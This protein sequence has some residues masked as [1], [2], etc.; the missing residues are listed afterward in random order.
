M[1][2]KSQ[3]SARYLFVI[4]AY[5]GNEKHL[6]DSYN[7]F[8]NINEDFHFL[9]RHY[10][11]DYAHP[12]FGLTY[13]DMNPMS[14]DKLLSWATWAREEIMF[15]RKFYRN[16]TL[17]L[18]NFQKPPSDFELM[19]I[20]IRISQ[21]MSTVSP[22][23]I[24][25]G[26]PDNWIGTLIGRIA[27]DLCIPNGYAFE[28]SILNNLFFNSFGYSN[29]NPLIVPS[30]FT[31]INDD[32][33][34]PVPAIELSMNRKDPKVYT[35]NRKP[36]VQRFTDITQ[37]EWHAF[38]LLL[39][40]KRVG[41]SPWQYADHWFPILS[42]LK[43]WSMK[44]LGFWNRYQLR[45]WEQMGWIKFVNSTKPRCLVFLHA[46]PEAATLFFGRKL[47]TQAGFIKLL[48]QRLGNDFEI[49]VKEHPDQNL[50][51]R[52][53]N[54]LKEIKGLSAGFLPREL[55][56]SLLAKEVELIAT[57]QGSV[58]IEAAEIGS[59]VVLGVDNTWISKLPN[60]VE[61]TSPNLPKLLQSLSEKTCPLLPDGNTFNLE[62]FLS[63]M[64]SDSVLIAASGDVEAQIKVARSRA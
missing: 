24:G 44:M 18:P 50:M 26:H 60:V 53:H 11:C 37:R 41:N 16:E 38:K 56:L 64:L 58:A 9:T 39:M 30:Y 48:T 34:V 40:R 13:D 49:F 46:E 43:F 19:Q 14:E 63:P 4:N 17:R 10:V 12:L 29:N 52:R 55:K 6:C 27:D 61:L 20:S 59:V 57:L 23:Y 1:K 21:I 32:P 36:Y 2:S 7:K 22:S 25:L 28:L 62:Q 33:I 42:L 35:S 54:F 5:Q 47:G 8:R 15:D 31:N 3:S 45:S 51:L